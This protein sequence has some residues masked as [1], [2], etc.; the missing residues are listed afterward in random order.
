MKEI[1]TIPFLIAGAA[2]AFAAAAG[3]TV[4]TFYGCPRRFALVTAA[5]TAPTAFYGSVAF[6]EYIKGFGA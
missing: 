1:H 3:M 5:V 4:G 6:L 2:T